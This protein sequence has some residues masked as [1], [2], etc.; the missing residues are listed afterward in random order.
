MENKKLDF[1]SFGNE[2]KRKYP[3]Y[4]GLD[5]YTL[6]K[7]VVKKYPEYAPFVNFGDTLQ[8]K[9]STDNSLPGKVAQEQVKGANYV[10]EGIQKGAEQYQQGVDEANQSGSL[11]DSFKGILKATGGL[12][13]G[14]T[15]SITGATEAILAP[16]TVVLSPVVSKGIEILKQQNPTLGNAIDAITPKIHEFADKNPEV[17]KDVNDVVTIATF[18]LG[19]GASESTLKETLTKDTLKSTIMEDASTIKNSVKE[20]INTLDEGLGK[21]KG[22]VLSKF[23]SKTPEE[24]LATPE[25]KVYKLNTDERQFYFDAQK[26]AINKKHLAMETGVKEKLATR[27]NEIQNEAEALQ[28]E[29]DTTS[30][31]EVI[32]LRPKIRKA[33]GEQSAEYRRLVDEEISTIKDA[34]VSKKDLNTYI[35]RR[36]AAN[37]EQSQAIKDMLGMSETGEETTVGKIYEKSQALGQD[38]SSAAKKGTRVY[39]AQEKMI[40]D[41]IST[42]V[43]FMKE[44]NGVDFKQARQ[45]WAKYAPVRN[46]LVSESKPFLQAPIQTKTFAN[47]L[48]RIA[49]GTDINNENFIKEV[50]NLLGEPLAKEQ[51]Q[52]V[53]KLSANEKESLAAKVEAEAEKADIQLAK[54]QELKKLSEK[55]LK[56]KQSSLK[57]KIFRGIIYGTIGGG[58]LFEVGKKTAQAVG[59]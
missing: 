8:E 58:T 3:E 38:I 32:N 28:K 54:E 42:L 48:S 4:E 26:E 56:V 36:Y 51:K 57:R 40:D 18:L 19:G 33:L 15:R 21:V 43:D 14:G 49:K 24:I 47:T 11:W 5:N 9:L 6:S 55:E 17:M 27:T 44:N 12:L 22:K 52:I 41:A 1:N 25:D 34:P 50:E 46:Q 10:K 30:R 31:D 35:D 16:A 13:R 20:G 7:E 59:L 2:I 29:L 37:P 39:T 23:S 53:S 45:F